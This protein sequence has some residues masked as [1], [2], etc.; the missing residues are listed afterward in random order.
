MHQE[1][2]DSVL[3]PLYLEC[4]PNEE[5]PHVTRRPMD[6]RRDQL[7]AQLQRLERQL[8]EQRR[9]DETRLRIVLGGAV[10]TELQEMV[11][12][13]EERLPSVAGY[14]RALIGRRVTR[15]A[16]AR[17]RELLERHLAD[18]ETQFAQPPEAPATPGAA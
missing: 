7:Q 17:V 12:R 13:R 10:L 5:E 6:E 14:Y 4:G 18:L 16:D 9:A 8:R 15:T 3:D 2:R 1:V 11:A